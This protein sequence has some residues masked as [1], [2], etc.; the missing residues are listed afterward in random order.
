MATTPRPT[1]QHY[2]PEFYLRHFTNNDGR[3]ITYD[4]LSNSV[5][6]SIPKETAVETNFY[7]I[8]TDSGVYR[9]SIEH[10]LHSVESDAAPLYDRVA[11]GEVLT[12]QDR[13]DF[14][15]FLASLYVRTPAMVRAAAELAGAMSQH[16]SNA[17]FSSRQAF[18]ASM[19]SFDRSRGLEPNPQERDELF[20]YYG[21]KNFTLQVSRKM[22]LRVLGSAD[23]IVEIMMD[24]AW[25]TFS[26]V[27]QH[28]ITSDHP[29]SVVSPHE[30][31]HPVYGDGGFLNKHVTVSLPLTPAKV[32]ILKWRADQPA[33][34]YPLD[35]STARNLNVQRAFFAERY[36]YGSK[37][38]AGIQAL[39]Q[40]YNR[41]SVRFST[42]NQDAIVP[43]EIVRKIT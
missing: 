25:A 1:K 20:K 21:D 5:R 43:M 42:S 38:D 39:G 22:G 6:E 10:W 41:P 34:I 8:Q 15:I 16:L 33:G 35:R 7:S 30:T 9:D 2:V 23:K 24:M 32:L 28:L 3:V 40:K 26:S 31:A 37:R 17:V 11:R 4:T 12:G 13:A 36:L 14:A 29:V 18:E 19:D 27:N